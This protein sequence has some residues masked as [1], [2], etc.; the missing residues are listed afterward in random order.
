MKSWAGRVNSLP[1]NSRNVHQHFFFWVAL[2]V[3]S[4]LVIIM[5]YNGVKKESEWQSINYVLSISFYSV[6]CQIVN[7]F[8]FGHL[9]PNN[10]LFRGTT[11]QFK[12]I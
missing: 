8:L 5:C 7:N 2:F 10:G 9:G 11:F 6:L 12:R 3:L 1:L 4:T